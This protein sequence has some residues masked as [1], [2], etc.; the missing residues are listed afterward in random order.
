MQHENHLFRDEWVSRVAQGMLGVSP[1]QIDRWRA[2]RRPYLVQAL[3]ESGLTRIDRIAD[4]VRSAFR[5]GFTAL[6]AP[7]EKATLALVPEKILRKHHVLPT[8]AESKKIELAM[9]NPLDEEAIQ[10]TRWASNRE[11]VPLFC[12]P[13]RLGEMLRG[14]LG[15]DAV[16]FNL[17]GRI[18]SPAPV[19]MLG[20]ASDD[21]PAEQTEVRAPVIQLV[22]AI[23]A[24]AVTRRAS[25][26]HIEHDDTSST[27]RF[28]IDGMLRNVLTLPRYL[29]VGPVVSRIKI[30][31][32]LDVSDRLRPQDGRA[33]LRVG[34]TDFGL[35]VSTLPTR[36]GE[37]VVMRLLDER[38]IQV[39]LETLGVA[40]ALLGR[41]R[42][43][44]ARKQGMFLVTG[45]TGSGKTTMLYAAVNARRSESVN[46][47]TVEDPVE[48]KLAG[49][50]QV[51][52]NERQ[53]L[54]FA[55][56]LR[57]VLR[58]DPDVVLL[59]EIR[60]QE[61]AMTAIQAAMT[62]HL[63]LS[64]LHTNDAIGAVTRLR[65]M[66]VEPFRVASAVIGVTA[67]R[68]VRRA[69]LHCAAPAPAEALPPPVRSAM[70]ASGIAARHVQAPGCAECAFSGFKGRLPLVELLEITPDLREAIGANT[71]GDQLRERALASGALHTLELDALMRLSGGDSTLDE[72]LPYLQDDRLRQMG[73]GATAPRPAVAEAPIALA[74]DNARSD[75]APQGGVAVI[76]TADGVR[77]DA[78]AAALAE[79]DMQVHTA[80]DGATALSLAARHRPALLLADLE[81]PGGLDG[82]QVIR[83]LT[84]VLA[85]DVTT[86]LLVPPE[87]AG[88]Q[89]DLMD[90]GAT[91]VV[92]VTRSAAEI[93]ERARAALERKH[94]W[95]D[96]AEI[97]RP[98]RPSNDAA[99]VAGLRGL[100]LLDTGPEERF[101]KVTRTAQRL[102]N[103][104]IALVTLVDE[105][106]Q[107]FKSNQGL[108]VPETP[109]DVSFCA[110]AINDSDVMVIPDAALDARFAENPL[111]T[112]DPHI[113]FYA[114]YPISSAEGHKLG[115]LC[116]IDRQPREM[117]AQDEQSLRDL[118]AMVE[119]EIRRR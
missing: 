71:S 36:V 43:L 17:L 11:V 35:R 40:P 59:G 8:R 94:G 90:A 54:T 58:Q 98:P 96:A 9:L 3:V 53:G 100:G 89:R 82:T 25:D 60:D 81:L 48:Y 45:P 78:L 24:D 33:K 39:S 1:E 4:A 2:E 10:A 72:I 32:R 69:C 22:N 12:P 113:R 23:I 92:E 107:W 47:V 44:I 37:K 99:R 51:Q 29:G 57:S 83:T 85:L 56:V 119:A 13:D 66:G 64:T 88:R 109:R 50:N 61:T 74:V 114:G 16:I 26:I 116:I 115:T 14:T 118:G 31:A 68:L 73:S 106:R 7:P 42:A 63:V 46:V 86:V 18:P 27:V 38:A 34:G 93:R 6:D 79:A 49:I 117:S 62:G 19:E 80:A 97:M 77:R 28:R 65:D 110:H 20:A 105:D 108:G 101:D 111:V 21:A 76:A 112:G 103:V 67:Q 5:I 30:M 95:S 70:Q 15:A 84:S 102:F 87:H 75:Q 104:P 41:M 91:D 55:S 52:V